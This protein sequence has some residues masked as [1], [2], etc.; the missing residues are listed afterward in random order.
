MSPCG[1]KPAWIA[2]KD[3]RFSEINSCQRAFTFI[4]AAA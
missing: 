2:E 4:A 1:I 3:A